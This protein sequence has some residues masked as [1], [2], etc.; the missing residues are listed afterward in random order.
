M[1]TITNGRP[2]IVLETLTAQD[3]RE[4]RTKLRKICPAAEY[5]GMGMMELEAFYKPFK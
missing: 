1:Q 2:L 4:V 5:T 3:P